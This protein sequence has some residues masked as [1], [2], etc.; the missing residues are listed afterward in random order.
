MQGSKVSKENGFIPM[1]GTLKESTLGQNYDGLPSPSRESKS[2]K[3]TSAINKS[4]QT[5]E[6]I[7]K[8]VVYS[9]SIQINRIDQRV[10]SFLQNPVHER[11]ISHCIYRHFL[12]SRRVI[13]DVLSPSIAERICLKS[14]K[15]LR[16]CVF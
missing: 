9:S 12:C 4:P 10:K 13:L 3:I 8:A 1:C 14:V 11:T 6:S 15:R 2:F 7:T 16:V 5:G